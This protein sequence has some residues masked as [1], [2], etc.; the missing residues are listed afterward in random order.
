MFAKWPDKDPDAIKDYNVDWSSRLLVGETITDS[1]W[2]T[3]DPALVIGNSGLHLPT[4]VDGVC[5][6]WLSGGAAGATYTVKNHITTSR[7]MED[8]IST[9]IKVKEQ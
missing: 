4:I 7:G 3:S 5:T 6:C 1:T 8:D 9:L 2:T